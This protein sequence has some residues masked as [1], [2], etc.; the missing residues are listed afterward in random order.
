MISKGIECIR[1]NSLKTLSETW[2]SSIPSEQIATNILA[3]KIQNCNIFTDAKRRNVSV[4]TVW[5]PNIL[6]GR[7]REFPG[8]FLNG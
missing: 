4:L 5:R 2:R 1:L 6:A 7:S 8:G 3:K